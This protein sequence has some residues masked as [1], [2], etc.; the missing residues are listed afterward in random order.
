MRGLHKW[1]IAILVVAAIM[2]GY[3]LGRI[4]D[5]RRQS[6]LDLESLPS[7]YRTAKTLIGQPRPDFLLTDIDGKLHR[8]S[9]WD[10]RTLLLNFW[11]TWCPPCREEIPTFNAMQAEFAEQGFSVIGIALDEL[12]NVKSFAKNTP[13]NYSVLIGQTSADEVLRRYGNTTGGLPYSVFIDKNGLIRMIYAGGA[14]DEGALRPY[15]LELLQE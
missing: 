2:A 14:L 5:S 11:A 9:E 4:L 1:L 15:L 12:Q 3:S 6:K 7:T 8:I 10:G 13:L